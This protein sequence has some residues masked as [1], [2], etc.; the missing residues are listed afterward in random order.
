MLLYLVLGAV[1]LYLVFFVIKY[2][3]IC[4]AKLKGGR[5]RAHRGAVHSMFL[6]KLT[7][8]VG[9]V[10]VKTG[11]PG[12]MTSA[13]PGGPFGDLMGAIGTEYPKRLQRWL[14]EFEGCE[15]IATWGFFGSCEIRI[16][17]PAVAGEFLKEAE[18]K[19]DHPSTGFEVF[20]MLQGNGIGGVGGADW[21][22]QHRLLYKAFTPK[23][24][25]LFLPLVSERFEAWINDKLAAGS[26]LATGKDEF[27]QSVR[28]VTLEIM[29]KAAFGAD[30]PDAVERISTLFNQVMSQL[31][32]PVLPLVPDWVPFGPVVE[33]KKTFAGLREV[34]QGI[35]NIRKAHVAENT[36]ENSKLFVDIL[37]KARKPLPE[38][39]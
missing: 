21:H 3:V 25:Q 17:D 33:C 29:V 9:Y 7:M 5:T 30:Q 6:I 16:A 15:M 22:R 31:G 28:A 14:K 10:N 11:K 24:T 38:I 2:K 1:V 12:P 37:L 20:D 8:V 34:A 4:P 32:N 35:V 18:R 13:A 26:T 39:L 27:M 36:E 19:Y 23:T